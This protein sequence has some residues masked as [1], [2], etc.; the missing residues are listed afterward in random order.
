MIKGLSDIEIT[1]C[2]LYQNI[3]NGSI[4]VKLLSLNLNNLSEYN[5]KKNPSFIKVVLA[6]HHV[7]EIATYNL[8]NEKHS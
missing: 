5:D 6:I 7:Q 2:I 3:E 4:F 1:L 8:Y